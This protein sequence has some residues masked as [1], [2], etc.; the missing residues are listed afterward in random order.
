MAPAASKPGLA[1][2]ISARKKTTAS[3]SSAIPA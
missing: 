2:L 1:T 3:S